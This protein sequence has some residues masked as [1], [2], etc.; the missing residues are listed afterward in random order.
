MV[1][2]SSFRRLINN[3]SMASIQ[4]ARD[5]FS[6]STWLKMASGPMT[7]QVCTNVWMSRI[8]THQ[9]RPVTS[10]MTARARSSAWSGSRSPRTRLMPSGISSTKMSSAAQSGRISTSSQSAAGRAGISYSLPLTTNVTGPGRRD[11]TGSRLV[12]GT[13]ARGVSGGTLAGPSATSYHSRLSG[14][15]LLVERLSEDHQISQG[16]LA[17]LLQ[18]HEELELL[19][20]HHTGVNDGKHA[21]HGLRLGIEGHIVS[22]QDAGEP[23]QVHYLNVGQLLDEKLMSGDGN[24]GRPAL[25][26][27]LRLR[28][29]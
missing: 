5:S 26:P 25:C 18:A 20:L 1:V 12:R 4:P 19:G 22:G 10:S 16:H 29:V 23:V 6:T 2:S 15:R 8:A 21:V 9:W 28:H 7:S 27:V 11:R 17:L 24:C 13:A 14:L 3:T